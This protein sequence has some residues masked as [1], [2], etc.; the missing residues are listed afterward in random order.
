[1]ADYHQ[2]RS[3]LVSAEIENRWNEVLSELPADAQA[4]RE[5]LLAWV[6]SLRNETVDLIDDIA[7]LDSSPI[8]LAL[9]F[10]ELRAQWAMTNTRLNFKM[11]KGEPFDS[12]LA[13]RGSLSSSVSDIIEQQLT[14]DDLDTI[15]KFLSDPVSDYAH[16]AQ[17]A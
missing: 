6:R 15:S 5:P 14:A 8:H 17:T 12:A 13:F 10:V 11:L 7:A 3:L 16:L 2:C 4:H 1:M 9:R